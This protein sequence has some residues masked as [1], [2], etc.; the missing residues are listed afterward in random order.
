MLGKKNNSNRL[1]L[2]C[3]CPQLICFKKKVMKVS[4]VCFNKN[5]NRNGLTK[6]EEI[7]VEEEFCV[8][9]QLSSEMLTFYFAVDSHKKMLL[10]ETLDIYLI[11]STFFY[12]KIRLLGFQ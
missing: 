3:F 7:M 5:D 11:C 8:S 6:P 9:Q 2:W 12:I 10:P 1:N 4:P